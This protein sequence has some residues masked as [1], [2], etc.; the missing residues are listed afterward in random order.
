MTKKEKELSPYH[1]IEKSVGSNQ[2]PKVIYAAIIK[3]TEQP[4]FRVLRHNNSLLLF[5]NDGNGTVDGMLFTAD[6]QSKMVENTH[7]FTQ[8]LK[9][10]G[11]KKLTMTIPN[12]KFIEFAKKAKLDYTVQN[13]GV[14]VFIVTVT[15]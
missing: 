13:R 11:I 12:L 3:M 9:L 2:D 8:A 5:R 6:P 4:N 7:Q 10:S 14:G 1:I 15:L